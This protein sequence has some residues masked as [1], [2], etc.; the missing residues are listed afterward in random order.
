MMTYKL[1]KIRTA[2]WVS[3]SVANLIDISETGLRFVSKQPLNTGVTVE[4]DLLFPRGGRE[5]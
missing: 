5:I 4:M 2:S 1:A 3:E